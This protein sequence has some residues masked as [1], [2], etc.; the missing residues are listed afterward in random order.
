[1]RTPTL[2]HHDATQTHK[3]M[4]PSFVVFF[5]SVV[6]IYF[7]LHRQVKESVLPKSDRNLLP[8][9]TSIARRCTAGSNF[10][11]RTKK[12]P[13]VLTRIGSNITTLR[14]PYCPNFKRF[15]R[16]AHLEHSFFFLIFFTKRAHEK[17]T[18]VMTTCTSPAFAG[19]RFLALMSRMSAFKL[20]PKAALAPGSQHT[21]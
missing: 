3:M 16:H 8:R 20:F 10:S 11:V 12:R 18:G 17:P 6:Y 14:V 13:T 5:S 19:G 9:T 21:T 4:V 7:H 15:P 1:M 2:L